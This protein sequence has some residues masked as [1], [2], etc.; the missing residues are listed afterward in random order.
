[1]EILLLDRWLVWG[2]AS[3]AAVWG[4][5]RCGAARDFGGRRS[6]LWKCSVWFCNGMP[7]AALV[8]PAFAGMTIKG[9]VKQKAR[10]SRPFAFKRIET[11]QQQP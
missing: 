1:M 9:N 11:D 6:W 10:P 7:D 8:I 5:S 3:L 2:A 4:G